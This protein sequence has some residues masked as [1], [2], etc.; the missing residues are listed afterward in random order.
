MNK[1]YSNQNKVQE[2]KLLL[3]SVIN[4]PVPFKEDDA[5]KLA[6]RSQGG[7]AKYNNEERS[8][9]ACSLNTLKSASELRL[10]RGFVELD[11]LRINAKD[12]LENAS[13]GKNTTTQTRTGLKHKADELQAQLNI[14]KKSNFLLST[15]VEE[16]RGKLK[17]M[18]YSNQNPEQAQAMYHEYNKR[19]EA[20][21]S[22]T[23]DGEV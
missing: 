3:T 4:D 2:T 14:M 12:A 17:Q 6:L 21:L 11:E 18:A 19:L 20:K 13:L 16:L 22:Y 23:L 8:I 9:L 1:Q 15:V 10:N 7:L 5:L